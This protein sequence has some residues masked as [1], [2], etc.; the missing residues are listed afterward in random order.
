MFQS[1]K[2]FIK[3]FF[4]DFSHFWNI[5]SRYFNIG[6]GGLHEQI[7]P[8]SSTATTEY[9]LICSNL[10]N[11]LSKYS[12]RFFPLLKYFFYIYIN[13]VVSMNNMCPSPPLPLPASQSTYDPLNCFAISKEIQITGG[14]FTMLR[15]VL[16]ILKWDFYPIIL[17]PLFCCYKIYQIQMMALWLKIEA[18]RSSWTSIV[19][20]SVNTW[21]KQLVV[22]FIS[23]LYFCKLFLITL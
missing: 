13:M 14:N 19:D 9:P 18:P 6:P 4:I 21:E 12:Y 3:I 2:Y 8:P 16:W 17:K 11:I 1:L 20:I 7:L 22:F 10:W 23:L 15:W 5:L